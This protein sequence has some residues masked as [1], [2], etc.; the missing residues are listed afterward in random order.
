MGLRFFV[1]A[2]SRRG[3]QGLLSAAVPGLLIAVLHT[4]EQGL[5]SVQASVAVA[6][7]LSWV[8][9]CE[10]FPEQGWNLC[11]LPWQAVSAFG[12]PGKSMQSF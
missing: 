1:Q 12:P 10:V 7:G 4:M 5:K 3:E 6:C 9:T 2:F 8:D 11:L